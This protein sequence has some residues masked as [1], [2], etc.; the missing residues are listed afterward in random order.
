[1]K[2][3]FL[4]ICLSVGA[5]IYVQP[6]EV[7]LFGKLIGGGPK[8]SL[9]IEANQYPDE[10]ELTFNANLGSLTVK[11]LDD[12]A[13]TV[14]QTVVNATDGSSVTINTSGLESG[15]YFLSICNGKG[16]CA[17]GNFVIEEVE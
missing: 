10:I 7:I 6:S 9:T 8:R 16:E 3:V 13:T 2:K 17:E 4:M 11:V 15:E 5:L 14:I 12:S 1:M